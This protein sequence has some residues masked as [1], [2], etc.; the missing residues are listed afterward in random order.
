[1][2]F[3]VQEGKPV[4][5]PARVFGGNLVFAAGEHG[6]RGQIVGTPRGLIGHDLASEVPGQGRGI[7]VVFIALGI[8]NRPLPRQSGGHV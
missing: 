4:R 5:E 1:M 8:G 2:R 3:Q 6:L 7:V